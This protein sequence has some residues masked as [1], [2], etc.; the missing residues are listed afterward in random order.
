MMEHEYD[1][2]YERPSPGRR[3]G[4]AVI[5]V[6]L[7]AAAIGMV[8]ALLQRNVFV[9]QNVQVEGD[10]RYT[11]QQ[12]VELAGLRREQNIFTLDQQE[13]ARNLQEGGLLILQSLYVDYPSTLILHVR[14]RV[15]KAALS[16]NGLYILVDETNVV[17]KIDGAL[18]PALQIPLV[19]GMEVSRDDAGMPLGVRIPAQL[20]AMTEVLKELE[21]QMMTARVTELNVASLDNLYLVTKEG[22]IV[23]LGDSEQM[24]AKIGMVRTAL[25]ELT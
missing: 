22:L 21:L 2:D 12:V 18:D 4:R 19:T 25:E 1:Y 9:L 17:L 16:R 11:H 15:P 5:V 20:A 13:I 10:T 6:V 8:L 24:E 7:L 3:P 23:I 14:E